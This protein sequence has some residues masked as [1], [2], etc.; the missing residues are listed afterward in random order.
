MLQKLPSVTSYCLVPECGVV[1]DKS[2]SRSVRSRAVAGTE[3]PAAALLHATAKVSS[4]HVIGR[5]CIKNSYRLTV[6]VCIFKK[7]GMC[8]LIVCHCNVMSLNIWQ[9]S[10]KKKCSRLYFSPAS[11]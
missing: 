2:A 7:Y 11:F 10:K 4:Y 6:S 5:R 3:M 8:I 9:K 1:R